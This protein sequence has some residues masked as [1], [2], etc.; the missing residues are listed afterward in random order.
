MAEAEDVITDAARHAT[1]YARELWLRRR[2]KADAP[3]PI[4]LA[5][6]AARLDLLISAVFER[7]YPIRVAQVPAAPT[8]LKSLFHRYDV[9]QSASALPATDGRAIWLP[10]SLGSTDWTEALRQFRTLALLQAMR[11]LRGSADVLA[12]P[13]EP[14]C[15]RTQA[16]YLLLE[17]QAC[18]HELLLRLP[19]MAPAVTA[20]R[21]Q[22]LAGRPAVERL[23]AACREIEIRLRAALAADPAPDQAQGDTP[24]LPL[25]ASPADSLRQ[26]R[27]LVQ[28]MDRGL[29]QAGARFRPASDKTP[30]T[31]A[32]FKDLWT[33]DLIPPADPGADSL[34]D[35]ALADLR[36][37]A[38]RSA[39]LPRSPKERKANE[40]E[41][42]DKQGVWM[43]QTADPLEKAEDPMG[44]QRPADRDQDT[45]AEEYADAL[46]ELEQAR[47]VSSPTPAKEILLSDDPLDKRASARSTPASATERLLRY[48]EWDYRLG[49]YRHPGAAV[50][51]LPAEPGSQ[52]WVDSTLARHRGMLHTIRRHFDVL[53]L[54]RQ[55]LQRQADGDDIDLDAWIEAGADA[56]AGL[57][58]P[59]NLYRQ[60]RPQ[61]RNLAIMLLVD[62]SGSTD[63]WLS[64]NR[65]IIDVEREA[66]LLVA[67]ALEHMGE[68]C[69][70]QAFS[71]EGSQGVTVRH[72]KDFSEA[73]GPDIALRIAALEPQY[74][75]RS[76]AALRH[77]TAQLMKQPAQHRLL[78]LLSDGK[79]NDV[80]EY[81]GRYGVEDTRRAVI[82]ARMQGVFP[83]C[84]TID[85]QAAKYLPGMFGVGQYALLQDPVE[86]PK[87]LL[88]WL[89]KLVGGG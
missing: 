15:P 86:L 7:S 42:D 29:A 50:H 62:I 54:E 46:S 31:H 70:I 85:R 9:A 80:D 71:G 68:P 79:P 2:G 45:A 4:I 41:D 89:R 66:L 83:F 14:L 40:D 84:L 87:A 72:I 56:R 81:E 20:L 52:A 36:S 27:L 12:A 69:A 48:P 53:R 13:G 8:F 88:T 16:L 60:Q 67:I 78:L 24:G 37:D 74:Y 11:A 39:R 75:T 34:E 21:R 22:A 73:H 6:A 1:I 19:G 61:A 77:A 44:M 32:L 10:N 33:G 49:G 82:E 63:S 64:G 30:H 3:R 35:A 58:V 59:Q 23:P 47:L 38:P 57:P 5:Q 26:A 28:A 55:W 18:D 17:A 25:C 76:G 51:L 43:V 65:R